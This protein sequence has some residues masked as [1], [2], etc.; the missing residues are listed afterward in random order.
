MTQ[1]KTNVRNKIT[2]SLGALVILASVASVLLEFATWQGAVVGIGA[3][4]T[5]IG[6]S[7][8]GKMRG[9]D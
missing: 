8:D 7:R 1:F 4:C 2:T 5:L 3:G 9:K 6:Y